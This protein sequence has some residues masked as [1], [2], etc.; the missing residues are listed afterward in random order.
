MKIW[1]YI[2]LLII[3]IKGYTQNSIRYSFFAAGH[4]SHYIGL[5]PRFVNHFE[6]IDSYE[7][8][9]FGFLLG[10]MVT[11][12]PQEQDWLAVE[13]DLTVLNTFHYKVAGN[14]DVEDRELYESRYGATYY[15]I[16]NENDLFVIL[17][18]NIDGWNISG[19]QLEFYKETIQHYKDSVDHIFIMHHQLLWK[20]P[21]ELYEAVQWNSNSGRGEDVNFWTEVV[22]E[23]QGLNCDVFFYSGDVGGT[24]WSSS[25]MYDTFL[26][27]HFI[28]TGM[29]HSDGENMVITDIMNDGSVEFKLICLSSSEMYCFGEL[30][31]YA[32]HEISIGGAIE[33]LSYIQNGEL[34]FCENEESFSVYDLLGKYYGQVKSG[35]KLNL[36]KGIY[37]FRGVSGLYKPVK[38]YIE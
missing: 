29:G 13:Q 33:C 31:E 26:N 35:D 9:N 18:P 3:T 25:F 8:M 6:F 16:K 5:N 17:D 21:G 12:N 11:A 28:A 32:L 20:V 24:P 4:S 22:S 10:D 14:H 37:L 15:S 27:I 19:S 2:F 36:N 38:L 1:F 23:V 7:S 34:K 30:T